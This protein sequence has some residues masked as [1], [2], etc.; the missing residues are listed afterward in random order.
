MLNITNHQGNA[1]QNHS[2]HHLTPGRMAII[3][4][5]INNMLVRMWRK[6]NPCALLVRMQISTA[7]M[8]NSMETPQK[9]KNKTTV[10]SSNSSPGYLSKENK[11]TN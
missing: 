11:N 10:Q 2:E 8:E 3:K 1:N 7:T 4:K 9:I 5:T 6:G